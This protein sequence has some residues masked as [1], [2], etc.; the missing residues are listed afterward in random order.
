[1]RIISRRRNDVTRTEKAA[2]WM[3]GIAIAFM[4][5]SIVLRVLVIAAGGSSC[6]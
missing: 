5:A 4:T 2:A 3:F 1:M 6:P